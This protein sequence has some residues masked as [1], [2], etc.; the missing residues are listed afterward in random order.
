MQQRVQIA[1]ALAVRPR[2]LLMDE[3]FG[4]LDAL[5]KAGLQDEL[6]RVKDE[7]GATIIFITHDIDEAI[8]LSDRV[9]LISGTPGSNAFEIAT[10]LPRPR[11]QLTTRELPRFLQARHA[12]STALYADSVAVNEGS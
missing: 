7:T 8:Y 4:A 6:L 5:T 2:V 12:L 11:N 10:D 1:R 3:P 9:I